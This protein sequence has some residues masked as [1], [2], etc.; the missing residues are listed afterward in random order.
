MHFSE[1]NF[2][3]RGVRGRPP[4]R[5]AFSCNASQLPR[6][7]VRFSFSVLVFSVNRNNTDYYPLIA[8]MYSL[9]FVSN[10]ITNKCFEE[11][12]TSK[13]LQQTNRSAANLLTTTVVYLE[14]HG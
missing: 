12:D 6:F 4:D 1:I 7:L 5:E 9:Q 11:F 3:A 14:Q 8:E 10:R 2:S 13:R